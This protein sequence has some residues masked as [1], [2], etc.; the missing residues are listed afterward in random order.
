[1]VIVC[2][3]G[4]MVGKILIGIG[5]LILIFIS[6]SLFSLKSAQ[7][8]PP[9]QIIKN[10]VNLDK[11]ERI[12]K[13]RSCQGHVVVPQDGRESRRNMKHYLWEKEELRGADK[14]VEIY[15]PFDGYV[16][17]TRS[18]DDGGQKSGDEIWIS[19]KRMFAD[20]PPLGV[21]SFSIEH[22]Q[23]K[24]GLK[25]GDKVKAGELIGYTGFLENYHSFDAIYGKIGMPPKSIDGWT[26]PFADL[27]S[28]FNHMSDEV[29]E[30]FKKKGIA[31]KESL[32][33]SK[34]QR[35]KDPCK[36]VERIQLNGRDHLEE[37][38]ILK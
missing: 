17:M 8:E 32:I 16:T 30:E 26:S 4:F 7:S 27:D 28:V 13:Y 34:D 22:I 6:I 12:S 5:V 25:M 24:D 3:T 37:W 1:M 36:Y 31:S 11:I 15:A 29:F 9:P 19:S 38:M 18:L 14:K 20:I 2:Q 10:F 33:I 23:M 21:W 35:D